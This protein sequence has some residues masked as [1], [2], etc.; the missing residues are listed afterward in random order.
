MYQ[1]T[2]DGYEQIYGPDHELTV[3]ICHCCGHVLASQWKG[4][5][6]SSLHTRSYMGLE[7]IRGPGDPQTLSI[8]GCFINLYRAI[9][10]KLEIEKLHLRALAKRTEVLGPDHRI[11]L[12][13]ANELG[14]NV[15]KQVA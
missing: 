10:N 9:N 8:F 5:G 6:G 13:T 4:L 15:F 3:N 7:G 1:R 14:F 11:T 12:D 2:L